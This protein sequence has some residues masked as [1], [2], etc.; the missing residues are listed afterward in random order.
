MLRLPPRSTRT[1]TLFPYTTLFRSGRFSGCSTG[2]RV[3]RTKSSSRRKLGSRHLGIRT[4]A[5]PAFEGAT[6]HFALGLRAAG[7]AAGFA[8]AGFAAGGRL[9][10]GRAH[11]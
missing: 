2:W 8:V 10:I 4:I 1:D 9:E 5:A 11:V 6:D 7:L 3:A